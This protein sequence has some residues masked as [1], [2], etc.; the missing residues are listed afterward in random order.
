M[1]YTVLASVSL[2]SASFAGF[3]CDSLGCQIIL[4]HNSPRV[5][6]IGTDFEL[7]CGESTAANDRRFSHE[8]VATSR[9]QWCL[10]AHSNI[11]SPAGRASSKMTDYY[12][13]CISSRIEFHAHLGDGYSKFSSR[14]L[15]MLCLTSFE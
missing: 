11:G 3:V 12:P 8:S 6:I 7:L 15:K 10:A 9:G 13:P 14:V 5:W 1:D 2:E 4:L